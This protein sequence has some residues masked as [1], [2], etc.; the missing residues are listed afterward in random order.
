M[1]LPRLQ[2]AVCSLKKVPISSLASWRNPS[3]APV[4][5]KAQR[6]ISVEV[7]RERKGERRKEKKE[8]RETEK[9]QEKGD[10]TGEGGEGDKG[11]RKE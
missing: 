3:P 10:E 4:V 6:H 7:R 8:G 9:G 11:K 5:V 2:I 1:S